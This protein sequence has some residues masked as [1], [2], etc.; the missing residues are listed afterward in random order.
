MRDHDTDYRH[1]DAVINRRAR[2]ALL[3]IGAVVLGVTWAGGAMESSDSSPVVTVLAAE[4]TLPSPSEP[5][6]TSVSVPDQQTVPA[7]EPDSA[8][9]N[10]AP[11]TTTTAVATTTSSSLTPTSTTTTRSRPTSTTTTIPATTTTTTTVPT[12]T[13]TTVPSTTTTTTVP[14]TTTTTTVPSTTTTTI[15]TLG[16]IHIHNLKGDA[17]GD[18]D[19]PYARIEVQVRNDDGRDQE[20]VVVVGRFSS[21][22]VRVV[23]GTTGKRGRVIIESGPIDTDTVTFT[24]ID[25]THPEYRYEP[26]DNRRGPSVT[27]G[28]D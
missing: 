14:P 15:P 20:G 28:F 2:L 27:V 26:D 1:A 24:V 9:A 3:I 22:D 6:R 11:T 10:L 12:T 16:T 21:G 5:A 4:V 8:G 7:A 13:T 19:E 18:D 23:T 17:K 25:L